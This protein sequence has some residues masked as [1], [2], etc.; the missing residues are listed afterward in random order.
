LAKLLISFGAAPAAPVANSSTVSEVE[1]SPSTVTQLK[2]LATLRVRSFCRM[3]ALIAASVKMKHSIVAMS[4]AIMPEPL[5]MPLMVTVRPPSFT[6]A[7]AAL[8][9]VSV[10]MMALAASLQ[11]SALA[12]AASPASAPV[13]GAGLSGSP[14]TPVEA[15]KISP[16]LH[17]RSFAAAPATAVTV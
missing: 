14:I 17:L 16:G 12:A 8:A 2:L 10:V 1:V 4:G 6:V 5:A 9:K 15:W 3:G 11:P 7:V 13:I